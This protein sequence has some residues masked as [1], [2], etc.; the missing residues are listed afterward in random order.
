MKLSD[1]ELQVE[2]DSARS[3]LKQTIARKSKPQVI[4]RA[5][6]Q[7]DLL[8]ELVLWRQ[9]GKRWLMFMDSK[10]GS[11]SDAAFAG[12]ENDGKI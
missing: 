7:V 8:E 6:I 5:Q 9:N 2:L 12:K 11:L 1:G 3:Y 10:S 4:M